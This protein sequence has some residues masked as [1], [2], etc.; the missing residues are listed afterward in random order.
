VSLQKTIAHIA[1]VYY[2]VLAPGA[3]Q[4]QVQALVLMSDIIKTEQDVRRVVDT[5]ALRA[6]QADDRALRQVLAM[7][8]R[9]FEQLMCEDRVNRI[10]ELFHKERHAG[11]VAW[12]GTLAE[13]VVE[14]PDRLVNMLNS[15]SFEFPEQVEVDVARIK[16]LVRYYIR[17][18]FEEAYDLITYL[19]DQ[20]V[21]DPVARA[22]LN[23]FAAEIQI[24]RF[25]QL[26]EGKRL[27]LIAE[28]LAPDENLVKCGWAIYWLQQSKIPEAKNYLEKALN[29]SGP[30]QQAYTL[31]GDCYSQQ[32]DYDAAEEW[33]RGATKQVGYNSSWGY[34]NLLQLYGNTEELFHAHEVEFELLLERVVA[35]D[36]TNE[37]TGCL[38]I[39]AIYQQNHLYEQA[40]HWC[41]RAIEVDT[42]RINGYI[43]NGNI[44]TEEGRLA[45]ENKRDDEAEH[46]FNQAEV[47]FTKATDLD[48]TIFDGYWA[49]GDL[50]E[51]QEHW[52]DAYEWYK[53][54]IPF[55]PMWEQNIRIRM[56]EMLWKQS[57]FEEAI[58]EVVH[59][60]QLK[61]DEQGL[62]NTLEIWAEDFYKKLGRSDEARC[63]YDSIRQ[64]VGSSYEASYQNRLA[65]LA[66]Y[67]GDY[68]TAIDYYN[69]AI[70]ADPKEPMYFSNLAYAWENLKVDDNRREELD[71]AMSA[72]REALRLAPGNNSY[73][74]RLHAL[75]AERRM[76]ARF[77]E[78]F[79][80]KETPAVSDISMCIG[81]DLVPY[82][83]PGL[84]ESVEP[85]SGH[86][87]PT[88]LAPA[89][90]EAINNMRQRFR[91]KFGIETPGISFKDD[92]SE[93]PNAYIFKLS[94]VPIIRVTIPIDK[95]F[96]PGTLEELP[97]LRSIAEEG[98]DP[99]TDA[100]GYWIARPDWAEVEK[101]GLKL[102]RVLEYPLRHMEAFLEKNLGVL[103]DSL[104][105]EFLLQNKPSEAAAS[106]SQSIEKR[107]ALAHVLRGLVS[108]RVPITAF[109]QICEVFLKLSSN[110]T[111][112]VN[113]VEELRSL[114]PIRH[115]L[116]GNNHQY[117]F[118]RLGQHLEAELLANLTEDVQPLLVL[119][120]EEFQVILDVVRDKIP[121]QQ[122]VAL[123]VSKTRLRPLVRKLIE[124]Q[125][126]DM[127]VL[128]VQELLLGLEDHIV[129]EIDSVYMQ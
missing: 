103:L 83:D 77:G 100:K 101:H 73:A 106:I 38:T 123:L 76:V 114:P 85:Y 89:L 128:S 107:D 86:V 1:K 94:E 21:L 102:W 20:D 5:I 95:R 4:T 98:V 3:Q 109:N 79:L 112:L 120:P 90:Q 60:L 110:E 65:N 32:G 59:A 116:P 125:Y 29:H 115:T 91:D 62:V 11:W 46:A 69:K 71:H 13:A 30:V 37:Y 47:A 122:N 55:R 26:D 39:S 6:G 82:A 108:E 41:E 52:Q 2:D 16:P 99:Q 19:A 58:D 33:Y 129:G 17:G 7:M 88:G 43:T 10:R 68:Q 27:L 70:S 14:G 84:S 22:K 92:L 111:S 40:H 51:Q 9:E 28:K 104:E 23:V 34:I 87:G 24:Y 78:S 25:V 31:M 66:Y 15:E 124:R 44:Y 127:P 75:E 80:K 119:Q 54:S 61:P 56:G 12:L 35:M 36:P 93:K 8:Q 118:Y 126:P 49:M 64:I 42:S 50:R 105:T 45:R 96:C 121:S 57:R 81:L 72:L 67:G 117:T 18:R 113:I 74:R 53:K 48:P 63:L 97:G